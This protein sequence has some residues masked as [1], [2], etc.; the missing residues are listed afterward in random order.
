V[1]RLYLI[2][3]GQAYC[4]VRPFGLVAG[5]RGDEGLTPLGRKQAERLRDRLAATSEIEAD[6]LI[7][8]TLPRARQTAEIIAPALE[9]PIIFDDEV[10]EQSVGDFDG[11]PW[12]EI[13]DQI[14]DQHEEPFRPFG[15]NGENWGQFVLRVGTALN[16]ILRLHEGKTIVIVCPG[17]VVDASFLV[18]FGMNSLLPP[19]TAFYTRNTS[20]TLWER[21]EMERSSL[22]WRLVG[23]NDDLHTR[24][25][26]TSERIHWTRLAEPL[27]PSQEAPALPLPTE[28][29]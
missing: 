5:M 22:R 28:E 12:D 27:A 10:Q 24:D 8:S 4:N 17:G 7:A 2:R 3:H 29:A 6:V 14:P 9:L 1:T 13:E 20:I 16:R 19:P 15:P 23:Y 21:R 11:L 26:D 18:F 25:I